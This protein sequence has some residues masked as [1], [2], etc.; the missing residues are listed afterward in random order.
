MRRVWLSAAAVVAL[1][2]GGV[3]QASP[4]TLQAPA[5]TAPGAQAMEAAFDAYMQAAVRN[6][7]FSGTVLIAKDGVP[8]FQ[9]SY[10]L[11]NRAFNVPNTEDTVYQLQSITKPFTAILIMMLQ[12][13]GR[14]KVEDR[15]CDYLDDCPEAWRSVTIQQLLTH[16]S[17]IPNYSRLPDWDETLDARTYWRGGVVS[18]VRDLPLEFAP[19]EGYRYN[20][21]GYNL[22]GRII[23]RV[24]GNRLADLYRDRILSPLG[25]IHT[26]FHTSR[27]TWRPAT[28]PSVRPSSSPRRKVPPARTE[29][30]A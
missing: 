29:R 21:S 4:A 30:P 17:G 13:E 5:R 11:A 24:S 2:S 8:L 22:L 28:I 18:L 19:G 3:A 20:N 25:M 7:A 26:G 16:T 14:L 23:E 12:E 9:R 27:R 15:A 10:G 6:A 1:L